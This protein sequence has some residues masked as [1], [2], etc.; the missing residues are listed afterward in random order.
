MAILEH[1]GE[2]ANGRNGLG[3]AYWN[4]LPKYHF[5]IVFV[6]LLFHF[7]L[8]LAV[9]FIESLINGEQKLD[10]KTSI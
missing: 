9:S 5:K 4:F 2:D 3:H 10:L 6:Q 8:F 7:L 1:F